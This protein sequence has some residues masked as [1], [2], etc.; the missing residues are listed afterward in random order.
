MTALIYALISSAVVVVSAKYFG[1]LK[2]DLWMISV[3]TFTSAFCCGV[4]VD[5]SHPKQ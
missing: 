4:A 1:A 3:L 2:V 5:L